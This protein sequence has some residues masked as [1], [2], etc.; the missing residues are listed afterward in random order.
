VLLAEM[1][2]SSMWHDVWHGMDKPLPQQHAFL[3]PGV[4][5]SDV[6]RMKTAR[7]LY[8]DRREKRTAGDIIWTWRRGV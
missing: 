3:R 7:K 1:K 4:G 5:A 8:P 2:I 6:R